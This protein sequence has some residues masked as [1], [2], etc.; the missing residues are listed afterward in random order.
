MPGQGICKPA[1]YGS[2]AGEV[3]PAGLR[4]VTPGSLSPFTLKPRIF[5]IC[6]G[7]NRCSH[8]TVQRGFFP[9]HGQMLPAAGAR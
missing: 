6:L 8:T 9:F 1:A 5:D 4:L 3:I 7:P 2:F